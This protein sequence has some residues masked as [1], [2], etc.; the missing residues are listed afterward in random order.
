M[1]EI[2][3]ATVIALVNQKGG[4]GKSLLARA[5]ATELARKKRSIILVDLDVGQ[6]TSTEWNQARVHNGLTPALRVATVDADVEPDFRIP[7]LSQNFDYVVLDAPGWSDETTIEL[8]GAADLVVIPTG[9]GTDD[10]RPTMR[11]VFELRQAGIDA[12]RIV[13]VLNRIRSGAEAKFARDYLQS[14]GLSA[15]EAS[16]QDR[17]VYSNAGNAGL[18][19]TEVSAKGP[20]AEAQAVAKAIL[21]RL[22]AARRQRSKTLPKAERFTLDEGETW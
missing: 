1:Q 22:T 8:A 6:Q 18:A 11:L 21:E 12:Q 3:M 14:G 2:G 13:V 19:V 7:E 4:T 9:C 20:K 5:L 16:L 10:L 17:L 15:V